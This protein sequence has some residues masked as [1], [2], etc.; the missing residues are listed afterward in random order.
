MFSRKHVFIDAGMAGV[1]CI[2]FALVRPGRTGGYSI[3][4]DGH[5][6][7]IVSQWG[8]YRHLYRWKFR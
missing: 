1:C 2:S 7:D 8:C 4:L 3:I 5:V 6:V